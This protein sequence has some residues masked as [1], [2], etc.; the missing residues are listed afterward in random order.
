VGGVIFALDGAKADT[1]ALSPRTSGSCI[2]GS[3][4]SFLNPRNSLI[5]VGE[6]TVS[7]RNKN[8]IIQ[9]TAE[10]VAGIA[11]GKKYGYFLRNSFCPNSFGN[12]SAG[13]ESEPPM[14]GPS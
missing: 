7:L 5:G 3:T 10:K 14:M 8:V 12:L 11:Q 9:A 4:F 13:R 2:I 1:G 6:G